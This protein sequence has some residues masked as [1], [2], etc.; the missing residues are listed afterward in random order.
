V[1]DNEVVVVADDVE[2][3]GGE[4][5]VRVNTTFDVEGSSPVAFNVI[6]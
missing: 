1:E 5:T 2:L 4:I 3:L 6:E